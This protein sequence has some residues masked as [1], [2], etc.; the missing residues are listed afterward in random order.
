MMKLPSPCL[1]I[2]LSS[3]HH[4]FSQDLNCSIASFKDVG[5]TGS[6]KVGVVGITPGMTGATDVY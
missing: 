4:K 3:P 5:P 6:S 1:Q 2:G